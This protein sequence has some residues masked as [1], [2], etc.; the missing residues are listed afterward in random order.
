MGVLFALSK[1]KELWHSSQKWYEVP[2]KIFMTSIRIV[3]FRIKFMLWKRKRR[4]FLMR[5]L[6]WIGLSLFWMMSILPSAAAASASASTASDTAILTKTYDLPQAADYIEFLVEG[7]DGEF[8]STLTMP[9]GRT[10][11]M[12]TASKID[13]P[14]KPYWSNTYA[15]HAAPK[16]KYSLKINAPKQ[17]YYNFRVYIPLFS[18]I[19][20]H[21]AE[22]AIH[23]F[24]QQGIAAGYGDG[25][26]GPDDSVTG[27][28]ILKMLVLGLTEEQPNGKRQWMK[29]FRWKIA[30]EDKSG[31]LG[32][33]EYSFV[34]DKFVPWAAPYATAAVDLGVTDEW[35]G[36]E[37]KSPF[38]RKD[39][40][41][42]AANVMY[43]VKVSVP[44][45]SAFQD[46]VGLPE[47]YRAAIDLVSSY[48]IFTGYPDGTFKPDN[49][50]TRAEAVKV[51]SRLFEFLK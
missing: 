46:T 31:E 29:T 2:V 28:A 24:V 37:L 18:D 35:S 16:G 13:D 6:K 43:M 45:P 21:W 50:V 1:K 39:V 19:P 10:V 23:S 48:S 32:K 20:N 15:I 42:L 17:A 40:A 38:K 9:N 11:N 8:T 4:L 25:R 14:V 49:Q 36:K 3:G 33:L 47:H 5:T 34:E 44:G 22:D 51:L 27:E 26:F 41:L 30:D 12:T 7:Y